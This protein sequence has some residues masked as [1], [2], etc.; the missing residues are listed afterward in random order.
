[1]AVFINFGAMNIVQF[2]NN[3]GMFFGENVQIGLDN[4]SKTISPVSEISGSGNMIPCPINI[5]NDQDFIDTVMID[6]AIKGTL[7]P[8]I[9]KCT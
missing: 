4:F 7:A 2:R 3:S 6:E 8:A 1:M 5:I 9:L